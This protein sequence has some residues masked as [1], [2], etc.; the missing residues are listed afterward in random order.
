MNDL[1]KQMRKEIIPLLDKI[2]AGL[3][4]KPQAKFTQINKIGLPLVKQFRLELLNRLQKIENLINVQPP[5]NPPRQPSI[6]KTTRKAAPK[7][8]T[9]IDASPST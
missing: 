9:P 8:E 3:E 6:A 4:G 7:V 2:I 1:I 5:A